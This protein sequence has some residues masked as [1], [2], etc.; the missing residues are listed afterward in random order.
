MI[1][2]QSQPKIIKILQPQGSNIWLGASDLVQD[3]TW[4]WQTSGNVANYTKFQSGSPNGGAYEDCLLMSQENGDWDDYDCWYLY[5]TYL[6]VCEK[7][8]TYSPMLRGG[9]LNF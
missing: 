9:Q 5:M 4:V 7:P 3:G 6:T 1:Q 8:T 2:A